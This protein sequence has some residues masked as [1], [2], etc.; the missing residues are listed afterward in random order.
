MIQTARTPS[1]L[2]D[3]AIAEHGARRV[4]IHALRVMFRARQKPQPR[5]E[6]LPNHLRR[7]IGLPPE[8]PP[9]TGWDLVR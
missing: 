4:I 5:A 1:V 3:A 7:D 2:I 9:P 8:A 6:G